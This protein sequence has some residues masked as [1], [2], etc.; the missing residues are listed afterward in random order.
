[1]RDFICIA[2]NMLIIIVIEG[3]FLYLVHYIDHVEKYQTE[4]RTS[5]DGV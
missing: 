2:I 5:V 1:M 4:Y 3:D